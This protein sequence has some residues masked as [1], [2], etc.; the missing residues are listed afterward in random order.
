MS[1]ILCSY[2]WYLSGIVVVNIYCMLIVLGTLHILSYSH[3][4]AMWE[5]QQGCLVSYQGSGLSFLLPWHTARLCFPAPLLLGTQPVLSSGMG[6]WVAW[7]ISGSRWIRAHV[8][9]STYSLIHSPPE[10]EM[11]SWKNSRAMC[12]KLSLLASCHRGNRG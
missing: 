6:V 5:V 4:E 7:V 1:W 12:W 8:F 3:N 2:P 10:A 11:V 9:L